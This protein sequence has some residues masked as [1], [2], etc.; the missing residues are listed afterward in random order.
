MKN[1]EQQPTRPRQDR[2]RTQPKSDREP[3]AENRSSEQAQNEPLTQS[4]DQR[5]AVEE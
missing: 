1:D 2:Q 4:G 3:T 5:I